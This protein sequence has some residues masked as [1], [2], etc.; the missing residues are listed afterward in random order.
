MNLHVC[1][2]ERI[3]TIYSVLRSTSSFIRIIVR[4]CTTL[5]IIISRQSYKLLTQH[6]LRTQLMFN[7]PH[8]HSPP[9]Q[10]SFRR[11]TPKSHNGRRL[12]FLSSNKLFDWLHQNVFF[13]VQRTAGLDAGQRYATTARKSPQGVQP[14]L[15]RIC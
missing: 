2:T 11:H 7:E 13:A 14:T 4:H 5:F 15:I 3:V 6:G 10:I 1:Q 12:F 9:L 8:N